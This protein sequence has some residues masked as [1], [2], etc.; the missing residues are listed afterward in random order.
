MAVI[1]EL[2]ARLGLDPRDFEKNLKKSEASLKKT[3]SK[4]NSI[5]RDLTLTVTAPIVAVGA[6]AVKS[7]S[8]FDSA[9]T[10]SAAIMSNVSGRMDELSEAALDVGRNTTFGATEAAEA[11]FF[12]ASA[13]LDV[14]ESISALPRVAAFA[15]AGMFDLA[16]ATDLLTDAQSALGL[17]TDDAVE[18][19]MNLNRVADV[20]V[21]ANTLANASVEQFSQALTNQAAASARNAGI[22]IEEVT[23]VLA[24]FADQGIKGAEAGTKFAIVVRDLSVAATKNAEAFDKFNIQVFDA[25]GN[26]RPLSKILLDFETRL[27]DAS[28]RTQRLAFTLLGLKDK[29]IGA[30][31]SLLGLSGKIEEFEEKLK[32]AGGTVDTVSGRQLKSFES[33]LKLLRNR[34]TEVAIVL[35]QELAKV[36]QDEVLPIVISV[37]DGVMSLVEGF[38]SLSDFSK[39]VIGGIVGIVAIIGPAAI[40]VSLL[41]KAFIALKIVLLSP[42][43]LAVAAGGALILGLTQLGRSMLISADAAKQLAG[44]MVGASDAMER[45]AKAGIKLEEQLKLDQISIVELDIIQLRSQILGLES[46]FREGKFTSEELNANQQVIENM[47][48]AV[49]DLQGELDRLTFQPGDDFEFVGP[50]APPEVAFGPLLDFFKKVKTEGMDTFASVKAVGEA[51]FKSI[52]MTI[53]GVVITSSEKFAE[54]FLS[55]E[56]KQIAFAE[57]AN[58]AWSSWLATA[59]DVTSNIKLLTLDFFQSFAAGLGDAVAQI[60]VFGADAEEVFK[61]LFQNI[62]AQIISSLVQIVVQ[63]LIAS[64]ARAVIGSA[65]QLLQVGQAIQLIYLA[66]FAS[67]SAIPIIGP[68]LAP[69]AASAAA[70]AA[71]P[72]SAAAGAA[73]SPSAIVALQEGGLITAE[74]LAMLHSGERVLTE[75]E[76]KEVPELGGMGGMM[77]VTVELDG[78]ILTQKILPRMPHELRMRGL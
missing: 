64:L 13:G 50:Q 27:G 9:L 43:F 58:E 57:Q 5:G 60:V 65:V 3:A 25:Q 51:A 2:L 62:L 55:I 66:T 46:Q 16:K 70:A 10:K 68:A 28:V 61:S 40:G 47:T 6:L 41:V 53:D 74:G 8:D 37:V 56:E 14:D 52:G 71:G 17:S 67:I 39:K 38:K 35:G 34:V 48:Q 11:F 54:F 33:Q 72:L 36:L 76:V 59:T 29:S 18:N 21:K 1:A 77:M 75:A 44:G 12:L 32:D 24:A 22:E 30:F 73:G 4:L 20:L 7:F 45:A 26:L 63:F 31:Q 15:Q 69:A 49:R 42:V 78:R 23:A 19:L